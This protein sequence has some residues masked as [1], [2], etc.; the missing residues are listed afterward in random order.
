M[1][2][3]KWGYSIEA[4]IGHAKTAGRLDRN[5]LMRLF[6]IYLWMKGLKALFRVL[7]FDDDAPKGH[8]GGMLSPLLEILRNGHAAR[9]V[10]GKRILDCGCGRAKVLEF[11]GSNISYTGVDSDSEIVNYLEKR[12][13]RG[14]FMCLNVEELSFP[15]CMMFDSIVMTAML[16]HLDS[17]NKFLGHITSFLKPGGL[18]IITT[19]TPSYGRLLH[20]GSKIGVFDHVADEDHRS[21]LTRID[22]EIAFNKAELQM[23]RCYRFAI[24]GNQ[25]VVGRKP[26]HAKPTFCD[27]NIKKS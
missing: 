14:Q 11:L 19:P 25:L 15:K 3:I 1:W 9:W 10:E 24:W 27:D 18:V 17:P 22:I 2:Y 4:V 23:E 7:L 5:F 21:L 13:P 16:E 8:V 6:S 26:D 20:Y 12:Y